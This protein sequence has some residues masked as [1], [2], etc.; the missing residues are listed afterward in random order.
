MKKQAFGTVAALFALMLA[1]I[2]GAYATD[3]DAAELSAADTVYAILYEDGTLVFQNSETPET[4]RAVKATYEVDLTAVYGGT[5]SSRNYAPWHKERE[6][7]RIVLF[8]DRISPLSTAWWFYECLNLE[9]ID[10]I[11]NLDTSKVTDMSCM[12]YMSGIFSAYSGLTALDVSHFDTANV[13]DMSNMFYGCSELTTLDVSHFDTANVTDMSNMFY[14]CSE[15]TTLDVSHFDTANVTDMRW[16]FQHCSGLTVLDVSHFDTANVTHM[17]SMFYGCSGLTTLDVSSFDTANVTDMRAMF[18]GCSGLTVLDVSSFNT[19]NVEYM[20]DMFYGCSGLTVLDMPRFDTSNV[21]YMSDMFS[22]CSGLTALD[23]SHFD[24]AKVTHMSGMFDGCSGLTALDVSHFDTAK[25]THMSGMF[26]NCSGLTVLDLSNFNTANVTDKINSLDRIMGRMYGGMFSGC[27]KL[28]TIYASDKF[29]T[30][31]VEETDEYNQGSQNMFSGCT[32]LVG[33]NG[34]KYD[35]SH[36][37]KEYAR[38]DGGASAPG[39]FTD[40]NAA[41]VYDIYAISTVTPENGNLS[42]KFLNPG[43]ATLAVWY[44]EASGKFVS[45]QL[46][47][48]QADAGTVSVAIPAGAKTARVVLLDS[49]SKPLCVARTTGV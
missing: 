14:G 7:V 26:S 42:V 9:R 43:A 24:T 48:V 13:T 11:N 2:V 46:R 29:T 21:T 12:F 10:N 27:S 16:M 18:S 30:A 20:Q 32:S 23:V 34:T 6:T 39:Y 33:G 25:V 19:T 36:T 1:L 5:G 31:S 3:T 41:P 8:A 4:G 15:L 40:K 38:I 28:K 44:F 22:G 35:E 45:A 37:D 17:I 47:N 49:V